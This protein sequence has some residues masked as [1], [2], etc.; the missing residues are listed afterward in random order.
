[1]AYGG[2]SGAT[3]SGPEHGGTKGWCL[4]LKIGFSGMSAF[5]PL[6]TLLKRNWIFQSLNQDIFSLLCS[7]VMASAIALQPAS[8][9]PDRGYFWQTTP[10]LSGT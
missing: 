9:Q 2:A 8:N 3:F 7:P 10:Y 4:S 5:D 1:M 6:R